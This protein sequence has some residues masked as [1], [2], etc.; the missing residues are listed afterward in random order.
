MG[1]P[2]DFENLIEKTNRKGRRRKSNMPKKTL[3][4][5]MET[6]KSV[7]IFVVSSVSSS[8]IWNV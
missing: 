7:N 5:G 3:E 4:S 1:Y 8:M 6:E 2:G